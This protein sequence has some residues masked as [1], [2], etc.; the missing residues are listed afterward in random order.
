VHQKN[1]YPH[2]IWIF[3]LLNIS[4]SEKF[5]GESNQIKPHQLW[6]IMLLSLIADLCFIRHTCSSLVSMET[7][8]M[9]SAQ[10]AFPACSCAFYDL[11]NSN[12]ADCWHDCLY[13]VLLLFSVLKKIFCIAHRRK[14]SFLV[15]GNSKKKQICRKAKNSQRSA[16][17]RLS[18]LI[19][20]KS[21]NSIK[22]F[23][24]GK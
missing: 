22:H 6:L 19:R 23:S 24:P 21:S 12:M 5:S 10:H 1:L 3:C 15:L 8:A 9:P 16:S 17:S 20:P 13:Y 2:S 14:R 4:E 7:S 11:K 18:T